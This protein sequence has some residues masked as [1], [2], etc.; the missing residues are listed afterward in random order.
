MSPAADLDATTASK[1]APNT[2]SYST[3]RPRRRWTL[4][5]RDK[6]PGIKLYVKAFIM[7]DAESLLPTYLRFVKAWSILLTCR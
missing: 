4:W 5:N 1:A 7:D 6:K 2:P 3:S